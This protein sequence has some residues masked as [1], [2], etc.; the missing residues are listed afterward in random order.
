[1]NSAEFVFYLMEQYV[2]FLKTTF[3]IGSWSL[4][5]ILF[6]GFFITWLFKRFKE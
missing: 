4:W 1:M 5:G 3:V 6:T 2:S